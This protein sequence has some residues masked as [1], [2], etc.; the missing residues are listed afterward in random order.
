MSAS[1]L[2]P[3]SS[4][5]QPCGSPKPSSNMKHS[6]AAG[7]RGD[8]MLLRGTYRSMLFSCTISASCDWL[9]PPSPE[10]FSASCWRSASFSCSSIA[11]CPNLLSRERSADARLRNIRRRCLSSMSGG[12]G[13]SCRLDNPELERGM[14]PLA[15]PSGFTRGR[16][17]T[18]PALPRFGAHSPSDS[19]S[20][21]R[22]Y[23]FGLMRGRSPRR[24]GCDSVSAGSGS[25]AGSGSIAGPFPD[26]EAASPCRCVD[27]P[28][29]V[30]RARG[31]GLSAKH[32]A[33]A[34][35]RTSGSLGLNADLVALSS[36]ALLE[37]RCRHPRHRHRHRPPRA[38]SSPLCHRNRTAQDAAFVGN[39]V[40]LAYGRRVHR[41]R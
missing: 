15:P 5:A 3:A 27:D 17:R 1:G 14:P 39:N 16:F 38:L 35:S 29:S 9:P 4:S 7:A 20:S 8:W 24:N 30:L 26:C 6:A 41:T 37:S 25:F 12:R 2:D 34:V 18:L 21:E 10:L 31:C 23:C 32:S 11:I 33:T 22:L 36:A 40:R 19:D 13:R 28:P